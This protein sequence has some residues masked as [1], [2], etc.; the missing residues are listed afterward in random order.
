MPRID[1]THEELDY[2]VG[3]LGGPSA[4][5]GIRPSGGLNAVSMMAL[6]D[7]L[8]TAQKRKQRKPRK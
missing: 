6:R 7:R 8:Q 4:Q 2:I 1:V 5:S 3:R